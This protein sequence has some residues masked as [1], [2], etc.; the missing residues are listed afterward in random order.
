MSRTCS[1]HGD[2]RLHQNILVVRKPEGTTPLGDLVVDGRIIIKW[3]LNK[4]GLSL[5][6]EFIWLMIG[7]TG[8]SPITSRG[9]SLDLW[10]YLNLNAATSYPTFSFDTINTTTSDE[11]L[12]SI[13]S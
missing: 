13:I 9:V 10:W 1:T 7:S 5:L 3:T 11:C 8:I 6:I 2:I 4:R 12:I